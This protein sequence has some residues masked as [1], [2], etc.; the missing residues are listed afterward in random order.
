MLSARVTSNLPKVRKRYN[1]FFKRFPNIV[2]KGLEQ[3]GVQLKEIILDRTDRGLDFNKRRFVPYS[4]SYAEEK[5][6]TVVNLQDTNDM[7]QSIDSKLR[8]KNQ[9]QLFFREQTQAKKALFHQ[10]GLGKLPERIFFKFNLKTE[11][12]I[13]RSFEQ[14]MKKEIKRLK[15]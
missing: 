14:F 15:I 13:R 11:K 3:A 4:P 6:K 5:G 12:L 1:L 8:N 10:K 7:L 2:T 9:V